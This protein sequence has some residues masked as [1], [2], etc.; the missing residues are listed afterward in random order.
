MSLLLTVTRCTEMVGGLSPSA[1]WS[2]VA[3]LVILLLQ[4]R[5]FLSLLWSSFKQAA[6]LPLSKHTC[7]SVCLPQSQPCWGCALSICGHTQC[8]DRLPWNWKSGFH[9]RSPHYQLYD[10][11]Q[12]LCPVRAWIAP[13]KDV[14]GGQSHPAGSVS[15]SMEKAGAEPGLD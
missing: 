9:S 7:L 11:G 3:M 14:G 2:P 15:W 12:L 4:L 13:Y 1:D 6:C 8:S 10:P 5:R